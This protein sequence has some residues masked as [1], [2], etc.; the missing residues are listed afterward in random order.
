M[1]EDNLPIRCIMGLRRH[2]YGWSHRV[3]CGPVRESYCRVN[4]RHARVHY[5]TSRL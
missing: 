2:H 1:T 5:V 4:S 3:H